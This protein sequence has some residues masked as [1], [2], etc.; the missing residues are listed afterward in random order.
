MHCWLT[1]SVRMTDISVKNAI[2]FASTLKI[3][4]LISRNYFGRFYCISEL[5]VELQTFWA[6]GGLL[7]VKIDGDMAV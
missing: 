7:E 1:H 5:P 6:I 4:I 2:F 3:N